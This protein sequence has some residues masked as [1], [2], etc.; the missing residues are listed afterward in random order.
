MVMKKNVQKRWRT[1][2]ELSPSKKQKGV[3]FWSAVSILLVLALLVAGC[4]QTPTTRYVCPD[5][6]IVDDPNACFKATPLPPTPTPKNA[7][8]PVPE[9][10]LN[11]PSDQKILQA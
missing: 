1:N 5:R 2:A 10:T 7:L 9:P 11:L 4:V 8:T 3:L 6:S